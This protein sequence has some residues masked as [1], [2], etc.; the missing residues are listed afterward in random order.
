MNTNSLLVLCMSFSLNAA[1]PKL[2]EKK[3]RPNVLRTIQQPCV[4]KQPKKVTEACMAELEEVINARGIPL[5][6]TTAYIMKKDNAL[7]AYHLFSQHP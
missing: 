3:E 1:R 4:K 2:V 6:R 7:P 5:I